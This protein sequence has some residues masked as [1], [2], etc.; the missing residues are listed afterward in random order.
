MFGG[1]ATWEGYFAFAVEG[2]EG[3]SDVENDLS[4]QSWRYSWRYSTKWLSLA[5]MANATTNLALVLFVVTF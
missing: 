1:V 3:V 4:R 5:S 2:F